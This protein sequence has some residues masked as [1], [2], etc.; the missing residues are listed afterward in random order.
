MKS[1]EP[2]RRSRGTTATGSFGALD[3][4]KAASGFLQVPRHP[5]QRRVEGWIMTRKEARCAFF[6]S[7]SPE[8][9]KQVSRKTRPCEWRRV[10][11]RLLLD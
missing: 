1:L 5:R 6:L 2:H 9:L 3:L 11:G 4:Y 8:M 10:L 7:L